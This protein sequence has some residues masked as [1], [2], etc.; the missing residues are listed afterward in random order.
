VNRAASGLLV[1]LVL[2]AAVPAWAQY[3]PPTYLAEPGSRTDRYL[4]AGEARDV[5]HGGTAQFEACFLEHT[6]ISKTPGDVNLMMTVGWDGRPADVQLEI[7]EGWEPLRGCLDETASSLVFPAH[8][9]DPLNL[10]YPLVF[11]RDDRGSRL[12]PYPIVFVRQRER[13]FLLLPLPLSLT[14]EERAELGR[15]LYP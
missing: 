8:D 1:V 14:P 6:G 4:T 5:L 10:A 3:K 2:V 9:G 13:A 15:L 12:V 11:I 7:E